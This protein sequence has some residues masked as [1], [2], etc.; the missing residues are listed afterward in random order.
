MDIR[1]VTVTLEL[2]DALLVRDILANLEVLVPSVGPA[3]LAFTAAI[4]EPIDPTDKL[5][6]N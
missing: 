2:Q 5:S 1:F 6:L 4:I 3:L